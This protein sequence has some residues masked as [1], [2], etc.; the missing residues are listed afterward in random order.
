VVRRNS[1]EI[2]P[3]SHPLAPAII[4]FNRGNGWYRVVLGQPERGVWIGLADLASDS[5]EVDRRLSQLETVWG[6]HAGYA[7]T[8]MIQQVSHPLIS[9]LSWCL[10]SGPEIPALAPGSVWLRQHPHGSFDRL[11]ISGE[12]LVPR[13]SGREPDD[14]AV[15][16]EV[17]AMIVDSLQPLVMAIR[18]VRKVGL[19]GL[20]H[21]VRDL[22]ARTFLMAGSA[23]GSVETGMS[24]AE[25]ILSRAPDVIRATP[26]WHRDQTTG[27]WFSLRSVCCLAYTGVGGL[28]C[29]TCPLL[30]DDEITKRLASNVAGA[31]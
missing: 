25:A 22:I 5:T 29:D 10:L 30:D 12:L 15:A 9:L 21:G 26:R 6:G 2:D 13:G 14:E 11:A 17:G 27:M 19:T 24:A 7:A 31:S 3:E 1:F 23:L 16:M 8:S 4:A 28:Y 18:E 20:W